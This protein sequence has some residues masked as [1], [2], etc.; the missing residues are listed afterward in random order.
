MKNSKSKNICGYLKDVSPRKSRS[1]RYISNLTKHT[2]SQSSILKK[3]ISDS[4]LKPEQE[5]SCIVLD[6]SLCQEL[7]RP[8]N[9]SNNESKKVGM[10]SRVSSKISF[11]IPRGSLQNEYLTYREVNVNLPEFKDF[12]SRTLDM[13]GQNRNWMQPFNSFS[14]VSQQNKMSC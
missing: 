9:N 6:E 14:K 1:I 2:N 5:D 12:A 4:N 7:K 13:R 10:S 8:I 11:K 3:D